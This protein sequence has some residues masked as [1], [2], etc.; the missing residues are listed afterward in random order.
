MIRLLNPDYIYVAR[1]LTLFLFVVFFLTFRRFYTSY[2]R[3]LISTIV[4]SI[5][6]SILINSFHFVVV[7]KRHLLNVKV[8]RVKTP[9][10]SRRRPDPWTSKI[11]R[12]DNQVSGLTSRRPIIN[13]A[14]TDFGGRLL[15]GTFSPS[16]AYSRA[17]RDSGSMRG[18]ML[19]E[20]RRARV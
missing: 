5:V 18:S 17:Y 16:G 15:R 1:F 2:P 8:S 20:H 7:A 13:D 11:R 19:M 9:N 3:S 14:K 6:G 4:S 10:G 12:F